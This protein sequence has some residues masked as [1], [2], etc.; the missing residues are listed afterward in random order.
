MK[1]I[2]WSTLT[3]VMLAALP[4][5]HGAVIASDDFESYG[6]GAQVETAGGTRLNGGSSFLSAWDVNDTYRSTVT[7][8][9]VSLNYTSGPLKVSGGS[10]ALQ[11]AYNSAVNQI[12]QPQLSR[13]FASQSGTV[14][15][16]F[17][18][19]TNSATTSEEDFFQIGLADSAAS[20]PV[21]S[22]GVGGG[23]TSTTYFVRVPAGTTSGNTASSSTIMSANTTH[24]LVGKISKLASSNY[25]RVDLFV[26]PATFSE[27]STSLVYNAKSSG[28][29]GV[30]WLIVRTARMEGS[31]IYLLDELRI[32][33]TYAAVVPEPVSLGLLGIVPLAMLRRRRPA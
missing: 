1:K 20:E 4:A 21:A 30:G 11:F 28:I 18:F 5:A 15:F 29:A 13:S 2:A 7:I 33:N 31:D 6:S 26:D 14:Y 27:P 25:N 19:Q 16:S 8:A 17:L 10:R 9:G 32:G 3:A 23:T 24:L 12:I 22:V